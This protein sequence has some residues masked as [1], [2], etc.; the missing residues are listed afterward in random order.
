M[1]PGGR[2]IVIDIQKVSC[3]ISH[4]RKELISIEHFEKANKQYISLLISF[5]TLAFKF[6]FLAL[7]SGVLFLFFSGC[8]ILFRLSFQTVK[9]LWK[10]KNNA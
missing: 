3:I 9:D 7:L 6:F 8:F 4:M 10:S 2:K 1:P 5:L